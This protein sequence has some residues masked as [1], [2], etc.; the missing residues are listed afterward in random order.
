MC[1]C[2][3]P[4]G[5]T[6]SGWKE[7]PRLGGEYVTFRPPESDAPAPSATETAEPEDTLTLKQALSLALLRS[8][9]LSSFA[10][11]VRAREARTLQASLLPNPTL[12][13]VVENVGPRKKDE[14]VTGG[15]QTTVQL[16]QLIE[17]GGKRASRVEVASA[18]LNVAGWDYEVRRI[19]LLS[20]VS[21]IFIEVLSAQ[22]RVELMGERVALAERSAAAVKEKVKAGKAAPVEETKAK[23]TVST[24]SIARE[25]SR[26]ELEA[27]RRALAATWGSTD[28][29]FKAAVGDLDSIVAVP[30]LGRL[31]ARVEKSPSLALW[32]A[33]I[34]LRR[35][36]VDQAESAAVPDVTVGAGYRHY[37]VS[38]GN[39]V[40]ALVVGLSLHLP[41]FNRNQ[42]GI[43]EARSRLARTQEEKKRAAVQIALDLGEAHKALSLAHSEATAL[44]ETV[45]PGAQS[46]FEAVSEGYAVGRFGL[47]DVLDSQRTLFEAR[48]HYLR[49]ATDYHRAVVDVERLLGERLDSAD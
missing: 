32:A 27:V 15:I 21:Q 34:S 9:G 6:D 38:G 43:P 16:G 33:E 2:A 3:N 22:K 36:A 31:T 47:L 28:P 23:V 13:A 30:A 10:W 4:S 41:I 42:G 35:A 40:S 1:G 14:L 11:E 45:L 29:R 7:K 17:L 39:D 48:T 12:S 8:P 26:S 37:S 18:E 5:S 20:L 19:E 25:R 49:A 46:A 24:A 44:R